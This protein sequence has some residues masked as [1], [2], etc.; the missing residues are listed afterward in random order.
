MKKKILFVTGTRA[1]FGKLK[2]IIKLIKSKKKFEV[3]IAVTGMHMIREYGSTY[4][5]VETKC[6]DGLPRKVNISP[7]KTPKTLHSFLE[8]FPT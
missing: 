7:N 6:V 4:T 1:D 5:E 3:S 8:L 2:S